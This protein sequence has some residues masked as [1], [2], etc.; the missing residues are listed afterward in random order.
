MKPF[1]FEGLQ[2]VVHI[3]N[4]RPIGGQSEQMDLYPVARQYYRPDCHF[5]ILYWYA[6]TGYDQFFRFVLQQLR[7]RLQQISK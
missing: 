7:S 1:L 6:S 3:G 5:F 2:R 4:W